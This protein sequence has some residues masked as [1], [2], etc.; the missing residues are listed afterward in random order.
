MKSINEFIVTNSTEA[1]YIIRKITNTTSL[2]S[3]REKSYNYDNNIFTVNSL[4]DTLVN[5]SMEYRFDTLF[6][7]EDSKTAEFMINSNSGIC[8]LKT[9]LN[10]VNPEDLFEAFEDWVRNEFTVDMSTE[11]VRLQMSERK[12]LLDLGVEYEDVRVLDENGDLMS[13][14][15]DEHDKIDEYPLDRFKITFS[16]NTKITYKKKKIT[17]REGSIQDLLSYLEQ[18]EI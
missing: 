16:D 3:L 1:T 15:V 10:K 12:K 11:S 14:S 5:I 18:L 4:T 9:E 2:Q 8:A 6:D 7:G 13:I 17:L